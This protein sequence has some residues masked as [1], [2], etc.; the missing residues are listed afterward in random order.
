MSL[1]LASMFDFLQMTL[2]LNKFVRLVQYVYFSFAFQN[3][4]V[5]V[6]QLQAH[7]PHVAPGRRC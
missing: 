2:L 6:V 1:R 5:S 3:D 4:R 7:G